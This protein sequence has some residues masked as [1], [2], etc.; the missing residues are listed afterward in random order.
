M[1]KKYSETTQEHNRPEPKSQ[2]LVPQWKKFFFYGLVSFGIIIVLVGVFVGII[3]LLLPYRA[4]FS[5]ES[6]PWIYVYVYIV[7][8]AVVLGLFFVGLHFTKDNEHIN[9]YFFRAKKDG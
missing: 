6:V 8:I 1:D 3:Q 4:F 7:S 9:K 5:P 2:E